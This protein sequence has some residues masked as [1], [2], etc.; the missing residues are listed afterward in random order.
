VAFDL[1][2]AASRAES[3]WLSICHLE[4]KRLRLARRSR[5]VFASL[6]ESQRLSEQEA[7]KPHN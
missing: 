6:T 1:R 2:F 7:A 5:Q 4:K 3:F